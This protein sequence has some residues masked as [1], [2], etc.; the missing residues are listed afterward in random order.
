[1]VNHSVHNH[2]SLQAERNLSGNHLCV[3]EHWQQQGLQQVDCRIGL[4]A[5][6]TINGAQD[7]YC[8]FK[9]AVQKHKGPRI[10]LFPTIPRQACQQRTKWIEQ[11]IQENDNKYTSHL[12]GIDYCGYEHQGN[13][14]QIIASTIQL[15]N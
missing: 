4:S 7:S 15:Y 10:A 9:R 1:M 12:G 6:A 13:L 3:H 5:P 8:T 14:E 11:F 2:K